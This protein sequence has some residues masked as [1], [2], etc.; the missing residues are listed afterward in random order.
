MLKY[1]PEAEQARLDTEISEVEIDRQEARFWPVFSALAF[2]RQEA[3]YAENSLATDTGVNESTTLR[4]ESEIEG[5]TH[6]G[7]RYNVN[8]L[9]QR[10]VAEGEPGFSVFLSPLYSAEL[11]ARWTQ[12]ILRGAGFSANRALIERAEVQAELDQAGERERIQRLILTVASSYWTLV[13]RREELA[14]QKAS[15]AQA[16]TLRDL[17]ERRVRAGRDPR[18]E[19]VRADAEVARRRAARESARLAVVNAERQ[20]LGVSYLNRSGKFDWSDSIVPAEKL[21]EKPVSAAFEEEFQVALENRPEIKRQEKALQ[22]AQLNREIANNERKMR[23]D[24]YLEGGL[25]G[26]VGTNVVPDGGETPPPPELLQGSSTDTFRQLSTGEAPFFEAGLIVEIPFDN[27]LR[28]G[29]ARQAALRVEQQ[30]AQDV[31]TQVALDVREALQ[32]LRVASTR[33]ESATAAEELAEKNVSAQ[34]TRYKGGAGTLFDVLRAQD[35]LTQARA[36]AALARAQQELEVTRL[37]AA[38]G[39]LLKSFG[40]TATGQRAE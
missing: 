35:Q 25:R 33:L 34:R 21:E 1:H 3:V 36:E 28:A 6:F 15:L 2:G 32:R 30:E 39:T 17:V 12:P 31:R 40:L 38:R 7:G 23:L 20:L 10:L 4:L 19:M 5:L 22:L 29:A 37:A 13:L 18:S 27:G 9:T 8:F 14:I 24:V 16:E 26:L 11:S